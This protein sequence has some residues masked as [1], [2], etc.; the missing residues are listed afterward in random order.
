[1]ANPF[2]ILQATISS[3]RTTT[4]VNAGQADETPV[5]AAFKISLICI[6]VLTLVAIVAEIGLAAVW[7]TPTANQQRAFDTMDWVIKGGVGLFIGL[8]TGKPK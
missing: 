2:Q 8:L 1:M 7:L 6:F 5:E 3:P 4:T